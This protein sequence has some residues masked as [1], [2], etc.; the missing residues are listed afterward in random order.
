MPRDPVWISIKLA[1][2]AKHLDSINEEI[3]RLV[4]SEDC[5]IIPDFKSEPG[6]LVVKA[7]MR[8][9]PSP[10]VSIYIGEALYHLRSA[11][12]HLVCYLTENNH[13]VVHNKVEFPIFFKREDFRDEGGALKA[14]ILS[15]IGGLTPEHQALIEGEQPFQGKYG[16][17]EDDPLWWLY[18]LSNFDRHQFLHLVGATILS[19]HNVFTPEW[20]ADRY[21]TQI[22]SRY[23][24]F[25]GETEVARFRVAPAAYDVTPIVAVQVNSNLAFGIAF[26]EKG[27][28]AG[29]PV[30]GTLKE[31][32]QRVTLLVARFFPRIAP[33]STHD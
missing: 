2:V 15:R 11:L 18:G 23:G 4:K 6:Y 24:A 27:P 3:S 12:D 16:S 10:L 19:G 33:D 7:Y 20:F 30:I 8:S 13:E 5:G 9:A 31:I 26:D 28:G 1:R 17:P 25:E 32:G 14:A 29:R 22:S 21:F